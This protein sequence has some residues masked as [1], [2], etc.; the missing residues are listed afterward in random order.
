MDVHHGD[1]QEDKTSSDDK[2]LGYFF[3][4]PK[5]EETIID[6]NKFVGK[7][8]FYLWN[9]AFKDGENKVYKAFRVKNTGELSREQMLKQGYI[10]PRHDRY[11][12]YF[13]D[14][15]ITLGELDIDGIIQ[16]EKSKSAGYDKGMPIY[17]KG[18]E[19]IK[20]RK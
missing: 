9:D 12:C 16:A 18:S 13:F 8:L 4:E 19:L 11:F 20:F 7:V 15:E 17:L 10:N 6:E 5:K 1:K 2:K 3:C 14:E